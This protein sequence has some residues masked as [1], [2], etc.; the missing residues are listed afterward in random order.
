MPKQPIRKAASRD[1]IAEATSVSATQK[2]SEAPRG[3]QSRIMYIERKAGELNGPARIGRVTFNRTGRTIHYRD[4]VFRRIVGGGFKSNY[5]S[6]GRIAYTAPSPAQPEGVWRRWR[7]MP[8]TAGGG[9]GTEA[10]VARP[11]GERVLGR[12]SLLLAWS[13]TAAGIFPRSRLAVRPHPSP[14]RVVYPTVRAVYAEPQAPFPP[15]GAQ[16]GG[17]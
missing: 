14:R 8:R 7:S 1:A 9:G 5:C 2:P 16:A 3:R 17:S 10:R 13:E 15:F 11:C 4:L 12:T 6:D